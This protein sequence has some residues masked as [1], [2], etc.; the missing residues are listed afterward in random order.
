MRLQRYL[1]AIEGWAIAHIH[2]SPL[3]YH[4]V[5]Q[6]YLYGIDARSRNHLSEV[7]DVEI[8]CRETEL[9]A[10]VESV[11]HLSDNGVRESEAL[12]SHLH[13]SLFQE[14]ADDGRRDVD[15]VYLEGFVPDYLDAHLLAVAH[16]IL[17][18]LLAVMAEA[19]VVTDEEFPYVEMVVE[20][21]LHELPCRHRSHRLV[22]MQHHGVIHF[23]LR[24][25]QQL[26][27]ERAQHFRLVISLQYLAGMRIE[28]DDGGLQAILPCRL[29]E[30]MNQELMSTMHPVEE[31]DGSHTR[32]QLH[33]IV[34]MYCIHS[35]LIIHIRRRIPMDYLLFAIILLKARHSSPAQSTTEVEPMMSSHSWSDNGVVRNISPP[36]V[37]MIH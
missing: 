36:K 15:A 7:R 34:I 11:Y 27:I 21:L 3:P 37:T 20:H 30:M 23:R 8:G 35:I 31:T 14:R 17:E 9:S 33:G 32:L 26:G 1:L 10:F 12:G 4:R 28:S 2:H 19:M 18:S 24:K 22:E 6:S 13:F 25:Q 16:V 29:Y 5:L